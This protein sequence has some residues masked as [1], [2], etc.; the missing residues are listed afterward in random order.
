MLI[1][2]KDR[3]ILSFRS[4]LAP[5]PKFYTLDINTGV[6]KGLTGKSLI[7]V[8]KFLSHE[9]FSDDT[10]LTMR[11]VARFVSHCED[12]DIAVLQF[13]D[14]LDSIGYVHHNSIQT[15]ISIFNQNTDEV[16]NSFRQFAND[17]RA[18]NTL[19]FETWWRSK[20]KQLWL[21]KNGFDLNDNHLNEEIID[22]L[23]DA[24]STWS[25]ERIKWTS[26]YLHR[27]VYEY[28]GRNDRH[29]ALR[30]IS[31]YFDLLDKLN[32]KPQK[33]DFMRN[34]VETLRAYNLRKTEIDNSFIASYQNKQLQALSFSD[35]NFTV[36][37]PMTSEEVIAEGERQHN[38]VGR[39]YLPDLIKQQTHIVFIRK[40][41]DLNSSYITCEVTNCGKIA[42][43][44]LTYNNH[45]KPHTPEAVFRTK[46]AEHLKKYWKNA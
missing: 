39:L 33:G 37:V 16:N 10:P 41:D 43:Y 21:A 13:F 25:K 44:L 31:H 29:S 28:Y 24:C 6:M 36:V 2:N 12:I 18:N 32:E 45:P 42:Q 7:C 9:Y 15:I 3:N 20:H 5:N 17:F 19:R 46:Y 40:N 8:P 22:F 11:Y 26:Y 14:R 38:C 1:T 23:Y 35:E 30:K 4:D 27:C 34:Y